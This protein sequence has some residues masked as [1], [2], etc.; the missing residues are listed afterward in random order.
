MYVLISETTFTIPFGL[1]FADTSQVLTN[2]LVVFFIM[3]QCDPPAALWDKR[4]SGPCPRRGAN[5]NFG[6]FITGRLNLS[7]G[8]DLFIMSLCSI[9]LRVRPGSCN[10]SYIHCL[11]IADADSHKDRSNLPPWHGCT[12]RGLRSYDLLSA[13]RRCRY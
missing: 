8:H 7:L 6:F 9:Q 10:L 3:F 2:F 13:S 5:H 11:E 12:C 4:I 1:S